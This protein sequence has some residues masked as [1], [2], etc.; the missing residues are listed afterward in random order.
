MIEASSSSNI[1]IYILTLTF[2]IACCKFHIPSKH[3]IFFHFY[4]STSNKS[5]F[6]MTLKLHS[7]IPSYQHQD[8]FEDSSFRG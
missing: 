4:S 2:S 1:P 5:M 7:V 8:E 3:S 6:L